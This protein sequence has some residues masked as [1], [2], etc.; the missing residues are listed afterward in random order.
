MNFELTGN[1]ILKEN[2]QEISATFKKREFVIEVPNERNSEWND[3]VKFQVTQDKC[4]LL[5]Q[6][7]TGNSIKV[8]FNIRG[9]KWE[10]E[11]RVNYFNSLE[12]WR[13]ERAGSS[14]AENVPPPPFIETEIP[15]AGEN[16]QL[17]F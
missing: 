4:A 13:I 8:A 17:P 9:R 16:D 6:F 2:T 11:G 10:K 7:E 1:L 12:A 5:D 14:Q 3:F 15:S